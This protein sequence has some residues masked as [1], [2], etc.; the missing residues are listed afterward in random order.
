MASRPTVKVGV[1]QN[2][3]GNGNGKRANPR[4]HFRNGVCAAAVRA[5]NAGWFYLK[6]EYKT[7][8][9]AAVACGTCVI[10][11]E[12]AIILIK[13]GDQHLIDQV[14]YGR[15]SILQAAALAKPV[16][17]LVETYQNASSVNRIEFHNIVGITD[18]DTP[19]GRTVAANKI[20]NASMIWDD[21]IMPLM[22][23]K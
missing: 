21:M 17:L 6:G 3:N 7:L 10:Y 8:A 2:G 12:A 19:A 23:A 9:E 4:R 14:L 16:V 18:L 13:R 22:A 5:F 20:G 15:R 1:H 11:I